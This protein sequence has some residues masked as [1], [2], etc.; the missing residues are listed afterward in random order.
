EATVHDT[1][2]MKDQLAL[3]YDA[4]MRALWL[5]VEDLTAT[6]VKKGQSVD[7][8]TEAF[9]RLRTAGVC[10]M[11]MMMHHDAQP[12]Y[13]RGSNYGLLNQLRL[14]RKAGAISVQVLMLVP[15]CGTKLYRE[16]YTSGQ[17][18]DRAGNRRIESYMHDGNYIMASHHKRPW[19]KQLNLMAAYL[20][21]YNPWWLIVELLRK[22]NKA[23]DR[24]VAMQV[25]GM[26]GLT[27]NIY[28]T[29]GWACRMMFMKIHR[30][31][32]PPSSEVPIRSVQGGR[33]DHAPA[34]IPLTIGGDESKPP[35][36]NGVVVTVKPP[37]KV[38][39]GH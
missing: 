21:F 7:K 24:P 23:G 22:R 39:A 14:L 2:K 26:I 33:A 36:G 16:T 20:Y 29:L 3:A 27:H 13:S 25:I 11:P 5:G 18:I 9:Q 1:L 17:V 38:A 28:R 37:T 12:L 8:T 19:V 15:A 35:S 34:T 6:L 10:P 4:G 30:L 32:E 31:H